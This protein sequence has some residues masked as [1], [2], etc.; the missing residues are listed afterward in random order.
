MSTFNHIHTTILAAEDVQIPS[1]PDV[2]NLLQDTS[3]A[4]KS[5]ATELAS[6]RLLQDAELDILYPLLKGT[7]Y[8][9]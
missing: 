2:G 6:Y 9:R 5:P 1:L 8:C 4:K 7:S 3:V